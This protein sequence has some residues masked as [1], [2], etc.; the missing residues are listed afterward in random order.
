M[1][2]IKIFRNH[3]AM[4]IMYLG[5]RTKSQGPQHRKGCKFRHEAEF[6]GHHPPPHATATKLCWGDISER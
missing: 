1:A 3:E 5:L 6:Q 4:A 2:Q